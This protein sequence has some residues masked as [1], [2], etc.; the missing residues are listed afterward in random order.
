M[1][2]LPSLSIGGFYG[3]PL[4]GCG[5]ASVQVS[6][7]FHS[8]KNYVKWILLPRSLIDD[9]LEFFFPYFSS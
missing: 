3:A 2:R 5:Q 8:L 9:S 1:S 6:L 7:K 4:L